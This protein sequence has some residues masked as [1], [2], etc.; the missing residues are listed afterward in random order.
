MSRYEERIW[1]PTAD[2]VGLPRSARQ[3][4]PYLAY[5]PDRLITRSFSIGGPEAADATDAERAVRDLDRDATALAGTEAL[6]RLLLR[7]E[8]VASSHIEGV[9]IGAKRLLKADAARDAGEEPQDVTAAEVLANIDAMAYAM[10][11]VDSGNLITPDLLRRT[12]R[13][14]LEPTPL[15]AYGGQTRRQQN[16]IGG[17]SYNP[18]SAAFVPP[19]WEMVDGL[20]DDLCAFS[21]DD[22]LP[23]IAQAAIA[24]AQFETIHP[25]VDGNGRVGRALIHLILRRRKLTESVSPPVS[26]ILA[27]RARDY[28]EGLTATRYDGPAD[29]EKARAGLNRW[30]GTFAAACAQAATEAAAF[31][32]RIRTIQDAWRGRLNVKRR[33]SVA[34]RLIDLLPGTP[35]ITVA[36][37]LKLTAASTSSVNEAVERLRDAGIISPTAVGKKRKQVYQATEI[38]DAFTDLERQLA[39]PSGDTRVEAP[40][41]VVPARS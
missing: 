35:I 21:N 13:R 3:G 11:A 30:L 2:P 40:V 32:R 16:W 31:E 15:A 20:L 19:P 6:A 14:L 5:I 18:F 9:Q 7:A 12:H 1:T 36:E 33:H 17:S 38:V 23:A 39:S 37:A 29:S 10:G 28:I 8:S 4:G 34:L 27:T 41:R 25:F 24:H 26:L 22:S